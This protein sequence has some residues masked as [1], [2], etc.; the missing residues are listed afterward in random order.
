[1]GF[2]FPETHHMY[3]LPERTYSHKLNTTEIIG[4][5]RLFNIDLF[6]HS[7][8]SP[9][10]LYASIPYLTGHGIKR[11]ASIAWMNS[12]DTFV[13]LLNSTY[14]GTNGTFSSFVSS[15]GSLEFFIFA[16]T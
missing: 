3:G 15:G 9:V 14:N 1:M 8:K 12:A 11:D 7:P 13:H 4:P 16:S 2:Y 6:P 5:Y 10:G